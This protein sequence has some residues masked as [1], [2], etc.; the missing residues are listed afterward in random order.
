MTKRMKSRVRSPYR[1]RSKRYKRTRKIVNAADPFVSI[2]IPIMNERRTIATVIS[3]CARVHPRSEVIVVANGS[4]DGSREI[5]QK[6]GARVIS[7]DRPLGHD[8]GR[9][10][11]ANAAKGQVVL[12]TDGDVIIPTRDLIPFVHAI[13]AGADMALNKYTGPTQTHHVHSV[14]AAKHA[15][16]ITLLR[17]DLTGASLTTIPHALNSRALETIGIEHLAIPPMAHAIGVL[18]GLN[19]SLA[20]YV[21]VGVRNRKRRKNE[22][23]KNPLEQLIVGDHLEAMQW[24]MHETNRRGNHSDLTRLR[25]K[26]R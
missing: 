11:G 3:H 14:V 21:N 9:S 8:V 24:I 2:V 12:F 1:T 15:L 19:V 16:N 13:A 26:V 6:M 22:Q 17:E 7:F 18:K 23:G 5:A 25:D 20:H 4:T 10:I